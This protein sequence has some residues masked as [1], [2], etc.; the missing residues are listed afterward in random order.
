MAGSAD[1][2]KAV[3]DKYTQAIYDGIGEGYAIVYGPADPPALIELEYELPQGGNDSIIKFTVTYRKPSDEKPVKV[4]T[5]EE[6]VGNTGAL[7]V[8][9]AAERLGV[10]S[11]GSKKQVPTDPPDF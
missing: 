6:R 4:A 10:R 11:V 1:R 3:S 5:W 2:E 7:E 9:F 8:G